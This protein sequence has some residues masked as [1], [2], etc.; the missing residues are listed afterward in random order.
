MMREVG[1]R[2]SVSG[3]QLSFTSATQGLLSEISDPLEGVN[4]TRRGSLV[5]TMGIA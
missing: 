5:M 4:V 1:R 2:V 3:G